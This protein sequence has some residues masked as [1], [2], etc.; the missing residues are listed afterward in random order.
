MDA[1]SLIGNCVNLLPMISEVRPDATF[2]EHVQTVKKRMNELDSFQKYSFAGLAQLGLR[3]LPVINAVFNMDRPIPRFQFHELEVELIENEVSFSKYELFLNVTEALQQLRL[4]FDYNSDLFQPNIIEAWSGYFLNLLYSIVEEEGAR[5]SALTLLR[6][7]ENEQLRT[8]WAANTDAKG[9]YLCVLDAYKHLAP[10]GTAGE[11]YQASVAGLLGTTREWAY[12]ENDGKLRH[13]GNLNRTIHIRGHRVNLG[14]LEKHL[15]QT[16]RLES[17]VITP[18]TDEAGK[19]S[20]I[21]VY[22]VANASKPWEEDALKKAAIEI[23]P[24]YTQP[25]FWIPMDHIP[26]LPDGQPDLQALPEPGQ[27]SV[28]TKTDTAPE[29]HSVE[30]QLVNIWMD[31]LNVTDISDDDNFFQLG[32]DSLKA[33]VILSRVNKELVYTFHSATFLS[34]KRLLSWLHILRVEQRRPTNRLYL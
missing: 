18:Q 23:L 28:L 31:V 14:Q 13:I 2:T 22:V 4:D 26:L 33:T 32:G 17:C 5:V 9:N 27:A 16:F 1:F 8:A 25:R 11:V 15:L 21:T 19:V 30:D 7:S 10:V 6:A 29:N 20:Y 24:D 34:C 3:H 12:V